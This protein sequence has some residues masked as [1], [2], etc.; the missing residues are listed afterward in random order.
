MCVSI[1]RFPF[2][3]GIPSFFRVGK[4]LIPS[5]FRVWKGLIPSFFRGTCLALNLFM[6]YNDAKNKCRDEI[7]KKKV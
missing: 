6:C 1:R 7:F 3:D 5:F 2:V 4:G